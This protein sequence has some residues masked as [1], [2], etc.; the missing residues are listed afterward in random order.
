MIDK[1]NQGV[2]HHLAPAEWF[3]PFDV[4]GRYRFGAIN[5]T[6]N[7]SYT[8]GILIFDILP[9]PEDGRIKAD[10]CCLQAVNDFYREDTVNALLKELFRI[11]SDT[12]VE[13]LVCGLPDDEPDIFLRQQLELHGMEFTF[14]NSSTYTI[15]L[16]TLL[17]NPFF[18][19]EEKSH[20]LP[21]SECYQ[22][23][24]LHVFEQLRMLPQV[25]EQAEVYLP[26]CDPTVS[27][28]LLEN[29]SI[30][31]IT[32]VRILDE[33]QLELLLFRSF[34]KSSRFAQ[35]MLLFAGHHAKE[36]YAP[37]TLL[38]LSCR[39]E[40]AAPLVAYFLPQIQPQELY[41]G[42]LPLKQ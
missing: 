11:L 3:S 37:D 7:S 19:G 34:G 38:R 32:L 22:S 12:Q 14:G 42:V 41:F 15:Q 16:G 39:F 10:L 25:P 1:N 6:Q 5:K 29:G 9:D 35:D 31:G 28:V 27:C 33:K 13:K 21:L 2:F 8:A 24:L 18:Q 30:T 40:A 4:P 23:S 20:I 26:Q 17:K 36:K